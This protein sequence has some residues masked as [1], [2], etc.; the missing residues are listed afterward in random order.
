MSS[1]SREKPSGNFSLKQLDDKRLNLEAEATGIKGELVSM[2]AGVTDPLVDKEGFPR[3]DVDVYRARELRGRLAVINTDHKEVM[4]RIEEEVLKGE[5]KSKS[6]I[7]DEEERLRRAPKPK[8]KYD[9]VRGRWVVKN[10]DG[11]CAGIEDGD[12]VSFESVVSDKEAAAALKRG[13][14]ENAQQ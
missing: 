1:F 13:E 7:M 11:S 12:N 10:W 4:N 14:E 8:P 6:Q 2:G 5:A 3:A 9:A